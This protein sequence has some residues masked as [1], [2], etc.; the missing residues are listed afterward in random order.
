MCQALSRTP[1]SYG[2]VVSGMSTDFIDANLL[3]PMQVKRDIDQY[4]DNSTL[5]QTLPSC[6]SGTSPVRLRSWW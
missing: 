5:N 6:H 4:P 1:V 2:V 3:R